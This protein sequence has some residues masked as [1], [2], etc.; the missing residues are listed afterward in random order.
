MNF[1]S[2]SARSESV[3]RIVVI[4][5]AP[6]LG[7]R[8]NWRCAVGARR[9]TSQ[10][11]RTARENRLPGI[12]VSPL[13]A[14]FVA[15]YGWHHGIS[16]DR[17]GIRPWAGAKSA[18]GGCDYGARLPDEGLDHTEIALKWPEMPSVGTLSHISPSGDRAG[19]LVQ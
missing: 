15:A 2:R 13:S 5:F 18:R 14:E 1:S 12:V 16:S 10:R 8:A 4:V 17:W 11:V 9:N 19:R 3:V 6:T 7:N